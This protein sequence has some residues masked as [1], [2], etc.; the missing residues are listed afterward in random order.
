MIGLSDV[1]LPIMGA[2]RR[3]HTPECAT[4]AAISSPRYLA[5]WKCGARFRFGHR[6]LL[7]CSLALTAI[8]WA[9]PT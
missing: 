3:Q 5:P 8:V 4:A 1:A 7:I 6:H 9:F 2:D